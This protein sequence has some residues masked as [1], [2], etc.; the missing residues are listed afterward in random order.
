M[1]ISANP[2]LPSSI[3]S[4]AFVTRGDVFVQDARS[5]SPATNNTV[6]VAATL[7]PD[8]IASGGASIFLDPASTTH[9][10]LGSGTAF[11]LVQTSTDIVS[12]GSQ[13]SIWVSIAV[14]STHRFVFEGDFD[15]NRSGSAE[16]MHTGWSVVFQSLATNL[17]FELHDDATSSRVTFTGI[18]TPG[19]YNFLVGVH[20]RARSSANPGLASAANARFSSSH[21]FTLDFVELVDAPVPEP[22]TFALLGTGLAAVWLRRRRRESRS[23]DHSTQLVESTD[24]RASPL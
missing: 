12:I 22:T 3:S 23:F 17:I 10:L 4:G 16:E 2:S 21:A 15:V 6:E 8:T 9:R 20:G 13:S 14:D 11:G 5:L 1:V 7:F 19:V 18:V 24:E